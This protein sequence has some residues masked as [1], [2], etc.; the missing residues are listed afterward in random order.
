MTHLATLRELTLAQSPLGVH[1]YHEEAVFRTEMLRLFHT[2]Y[3]G[4]ELQVPERGDYSSLAHE[5]HGRVL[6]NTET[7]IKLL[8]NICRHRQAVMLK[9]S[10]N[11]NASNG[12][13]ICPLHRWTYEPDGRLL[14]A[15]HFAQNPCKELA[16]TAL[17][18]WQGLLFEK[19][20]HLSELALVQDKFDFSGYAF[21]HRVVH[22]CAYNW[23]TFIEVYL[24]DYHVEPFHPGLGQFV[25][26]DNLDWQ[27][28]ERFSLQTVGVKSAL[29]R[30]GTPVYQHWQ[31]T[32][33]HY[34]LANG[35][36][37]VP[38]FGALWLTLYPNLMVE[39]YPQVLVVSQLIPRSPQHTSNIVEFYFPEDIVHFEPGFVQAEQ[40]A[41]METC[42]EDDEI[43][44]RMDAGRKALMLRGEDDHG[45]YQSPMEDGMLHFHEWY[46]REMKGEASSI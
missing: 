45:P 39:K 40:A 8:S 4:H 12:K 37:A 32:L 43:A 3:V 10:G 36:P 2:Q 38:E 30:F 15:P 21:S 33:K 6:I 1:A 27:Y 9:G 24:E 35:L 22:E 46:E 19:T 11:L 26:C 17:D 34:R 25:N 7:G 5:A 23:K 28:G 13:I 16:H 44:L 20:H 42:E 18:S 14:G 31:E 41:Y 29:N